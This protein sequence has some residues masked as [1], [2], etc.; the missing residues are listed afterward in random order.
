MMKELDM[1]RALFFYRKYGF[2]GIARRITEKM[3]GLLPTLS[4]Q[5]KLQAFDEALPIA[6]RPALCFAFAPEVP[7]ANYLISSICR[8]LNAKKVPYTGGQYDAVFHWHD[9]TDQGDGDPTRI[10]GRCRTIAKQA[11]AEAFEQAFGYGL[12]VDPATFT[13]RAVM[14]SD[15]NGM[16]DGQIIEC[17][18]DPF[19]DYVYQRLIDNSIGMSVEDLRT[20]VIGGEISLVLKKQRYAYERFQNVEHSVSLVEVDDVLSSCEQ[21]ALIRLAKTLGL[22]IGDFDVLRDNSSGKIFV[23]DAAKTPFGPPIK[24]AHD[25]KVQAVERLAA[26]FERQFLTARRVAPA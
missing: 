8:I 21:E 10:N 13:G 16:H 18:V 22:D 17:P 26:S 6:D 3:A 15:A 5:E 12:S 19:E 9:V 23:V 7:N 25:E 2:I 1:N 24:L 11:V 20:T 14:K 4:I